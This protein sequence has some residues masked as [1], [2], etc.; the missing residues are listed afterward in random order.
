MILRIWGLIAAVGVSAFSV[1]YTFASDSTTP[2]G[3]TILEVAASHP[4]D[5]G[6]VGDSG[7]LRLPRPRPLTLETDART[8]AQSDRCRWLGKRIVSLLTRDDAMAAS[9]FNPFYEQFGCPTEHLAGAFGC[10]I[11]TTEQTQ[12]D[13]LAIRVDRC[14]ADPVEGRRPANVLGDAVPT[15]PAE[16][17]KDSGDETADGT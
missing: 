5:A 3:R 2:N 16:P 12:G 6:G 11:A 17:A 9:D 14:W 13:D 10:V 8:T 15:E 1:N 7:L 4:R